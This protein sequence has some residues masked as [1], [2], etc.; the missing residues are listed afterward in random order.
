MKD[1]KMYWISMVFLITPAA[2]DV[3]NVFVLYVLQLC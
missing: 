1:Y 2:G 3:L